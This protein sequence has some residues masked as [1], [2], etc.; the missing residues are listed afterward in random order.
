M[1]RIFRFVVDEIHQ[2]A[3]PICHKIISKQQ[4]E[5]REYAEEEI[6]LWTIKRKLY[7]STYACERVV[8]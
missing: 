5:L 8:C 6:F 4:V 7:V 1:D 2:F 3:L